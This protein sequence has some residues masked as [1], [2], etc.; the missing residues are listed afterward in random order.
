MSRSISAAIALSSWPGTRRIETFASATTGS[1]V[2]C[3]FG[4]PPESAVHVDRGLDPGSQIDL[5]GRTRIRGPRALGCEDLGAGVE[6]VPASDLFVARPDHP[7]AKG[8]RNETIARQDGPEH[9][10]QHMRRVE[11]R[12]AEHAR[13]QV[14]LAGSH[15]HV[16]VRDPTRRDLEDGGAGPQHVPVENHAGVSPTLVVRQEVDDR[17]AAA[18]LLAVAG[19]PHVDR[20]RALGREESCSLRSR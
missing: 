17:L 11:R 15:S 2:F 6:L 3:R 9:L 8:L 18:L 13:V 7:G 19:E 16:E 4:E 20:E 10:H 5:L 12:A 1:T 14:A